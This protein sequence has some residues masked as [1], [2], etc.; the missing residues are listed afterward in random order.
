MGVLGSCALEDPPTESYPY[1]SLWRDAKQ[2]CD[3]SY[4]TASLAA[5]RVGTGVLMLDI[6][7][8]GRVRYSKVLQAPDA[9]MADAL[10]ACTT[11]FRASPRK[12][13]ASRMRRSKVFVYFAIVDGRGKVFI[14]NDPTQK[15]MVLDLLHKPAV[16]SLRM[17]Q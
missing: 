1:G 9:A 4:P 7:R 6:D 3:I 2:R 11:V 16:S 8:L 15:A 5:A 10:R 14:L 17:E 12:D 13:G